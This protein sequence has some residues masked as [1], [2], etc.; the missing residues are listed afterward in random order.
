MRE[1]GAPSHCHAC[2]S[3]SGVFGY[4][5][6]PAPYF[7]A[8]YAVI[9]L[10]SC[11]TTVRRSGDGQGVARPRT[12]QWVSSDRR[13]YVQHQATVFDERN[14]AFR[15]ELPRPR[16]I[17]KREAVVLLKIHTKLGA[18]PHDLGKAAA[19]EL[20]AQ[21]ALSPHNP[22]RMAAAG[23]TLQTRLVGCP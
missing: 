12:A 6:V 15:V 16:V 8:I 21:R 23:H 2:A 19:S 4:R 18:D 10:L 1:W 17:P 13:S 9:V 5:E 14:G 7:C 22:C 3:F 20:P 11:A